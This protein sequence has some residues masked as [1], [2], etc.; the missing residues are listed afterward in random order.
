VVRDAPESTDLL[1]LTRQLLAERLG[2]FVD[3]SFRVE[4]VYRAIY[5]QGVGDLGEI[6]NLGQKMRGA[7]GERFHIGIPEVTRRSVSA[8]GSIKALLGLADGS[9][10][11]AVDIPEA[12]R[13]TL[14][15]SSQ[16]GCPLACRFC[17]TGY[18]GAGRNLQAGEIVGQVLA[19]MGGL[20]HQTVVN[21]VFM[22]MGEPLLNLES[23]HQAMDILGEYFPMRRMTVSTAGIV[24]GIDAMAR[25]RE[26]PNL[27]VSLHAPDDG[28]RSTLMPVN[29]SYGL[30]DLMAALRRYPLEKRRRLTI[31]YL[32]IEGFNDARED[33]DSL[34][35]LLGNLRCKVNLLALN[36]D[37]VLGPDMRGSRP[38]AVNDFKVR[39]EERGIPCTVRKPRGNDVEA[40]CGRLRAADRA[41]RG[42]LPQPL[43]RRQMKA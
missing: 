11:E 24:P 36:E 18:W 26:R 21:I 16:T 13:R 40:G 15:I 1:G 17:V 4:Q 32:L 2:P 8:D 12:R 6:A 23:V 5:E 41:P 34:A 38:Q 22:G 42:F 37:A 20:R 27:A 35:T 39:V 10:V 9:T 29:R 30:A 14:C 7:L 19:L 43:E 31:E 25:W 28:R 3:R 33:A